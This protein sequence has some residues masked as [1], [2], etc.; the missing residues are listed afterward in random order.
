[1]VI[2]III[3]INGNGTQI[4]EG[5]GRLGDYGSKFILDTVILYTKMYF[6]SNGILFVS[7][8]YH[9]VKSICLSDRVGSNRR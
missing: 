6:S 4:C 3:I 7:L 2:I 9:P 1:M 5:T 8:A